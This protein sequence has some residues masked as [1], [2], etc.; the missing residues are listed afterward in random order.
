MYGDYVMAFQPRPYQLDAVRATL[1]D[2]A[3]GLKRVG[4]ILPTG[5]GKTE[6]M[7]MTADELVRVGHGILI[8][9]H[10]SDLTGADSQ[11][12]K[13][14]K[15]RA[16]H[17]NVGVLQGKHRPNPMNQVVMS[18]MQSARMDKNIRFIKETLCRKISII[19][20]DETH[21]LPTN[22]YEI[23]QKA[24]PDAQL[25]GY[26]AT[27]CREKKLMTNYFDKISFTISLQELIDMGFLVPPVIHEI[28][29]THTETE[30]AIAAN[31]IGVYMT[32][33]RGKKT[34]VYVRTIDEAKLIRNALE[35]VG[36]KARAVTSDVPG[37][38]RQEIYQD[39]REGSTD[40][41]V[42]VDVLTAGFDAPV[43]ESIFMPYGTK[44]P[45]QYLQRVGRGL[46]PYGDKKVCRVYMFGDAPTVS[47]RFFEKINHI[48]LN[49]GKKSLATYRDELDLT[50]L[51]KGSEVYLWTKTVVDLVNR[52]EKIGMKNFAQLLDEKNFP[53]HF[54]MSI[55][56]LLKRL[57]KKKSSRPHGEKPASDG[58]KSVLFE[59]GFDSSLL[60]TV[61]RNEAST[62]IS[63]IF[64]KQNDPKGN[65]REFIL[66]EGNYKGK[67]VSELP[68]KYRNII[69]K[70][71]PGSKAAELI[72]AWES[73]R[74]RA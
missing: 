15:L 57:P 72:N 54:M 46:R 24:F 59:A 1:T 4:N 28:E 6:V 22:S 69:K 16:P 23:I 40:V 37:V 63:A 27:P 51:P 13:R 41:L 47:N 26:T 2:L 5:A 36:V 64:N 21:M 73:R 19:M 34:I 18:T 11:T 43:I 38:S 58:Q 29:I 32:R 25:I 8:L 68:F 49:A 45:T 9:S 35:T 42:T 74:R 52:M 30:Q 33:E 44:S 60:A 48:A 71:F 61:T 62:M 17:L 56:E 65:A 39:F 12:V 50:F 66:T 7:A 70:N 14:F 10:L 31:V 20:V 67:H 55:E 53:K 3:Q